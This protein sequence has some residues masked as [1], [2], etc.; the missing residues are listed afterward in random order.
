MSSGVN[1][2]PMLS[3]EIAAGHPEDICSGRHNSGPGSAAWPGLFGEI[4]GICHVCRTFA[5]SRSVWPMAL[6]RISL[7]AFHR[8]SDFRNLFRSVIRA[9]TST[10]GRLPVFGGKGIQGQILDTDFTA[11]RTTVRTVSAPF[12]C[13]LIRFN[14]RF[15]AHRPLPSMMMATW[16]GSRAG[17]R[18]CFCQ[19]RWI[20]IQGFL[21]LF[22]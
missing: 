3:R 22:L 2:P 13:P 15:F 5:G 18:S 8:A 12:S 14:S 11:G 17:S 4:Y 1:R 20:R 21:S 19:G 9:V 6:N 7:S 10:L 16:A